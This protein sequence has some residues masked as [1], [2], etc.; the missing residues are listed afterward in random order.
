MKENEMSYKERIKR[1][2]IIFLFP[3][4]SY[5]ILGPLEI[6]CG[7]EKDFS[8]E[9]TDFIWIFLGISFAAWFLSTMICALFNEKINEKICAI[10]LGF[11]VASYIQ[12]MFMNVKLSEID[13]SAMNWEPLKTFSYINL[14]I[15]IIIILFSVILSLIMKKKWSVCAVGISAFFSVIQLVAVAFLV[16]NTAMQPDDTSDLRVSGEGQFEV[17]AGNNI[18][19]FVLDTFGNTQLENALKLYPD[20]LAE[21]SDFT[22]YNNADCHYYCTF[23]SMTH[24]LTGNEFDFNSESIQWLNDSWKSDRANKFYNILED[25]NYTCNLYS[26]SAITYTYGDIGNLN[27][28]FNN[29]QPI[30]V[31]INQGKMLSLMGKM[32]IYKYFP[33]VMKPYFEILTYQFNDVVTLKEVEDVISGNA[34]FYE[35]LNEKKLTINSDYRNA[36]IIQHLFGTHIPYTSDENAKLVEEATVDETVHGLIVICREYL[37]Q[38]K[39]LGVYDKATIIITADHGS[40]YGNDPQPIL[41][42]KREGEI[43]D[44]MQVNTAPVS[45]DDFQ[46]TVLSILGENY[47]EFG[48]S[49]FDWEEGEERNRTVY[50]REND[51][52]YPEVS[53]SSFNVYYE[54]S[55]SKDKEELVEKIK[56]GPDNVIMATPW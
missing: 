9:L 35:M 20:M 8:F 53:G 55:Y 48:A 2:G 27:R 5:G 52:K 28:K 43:H 39:K 42:V 19:V 22:F 44:Q 24:M 30:D 16:I 31:V 18:I 47:S 32:S 45:L 37:S 38:L 14:G 21:L 12:N 41:F 56:A 4:I 34:Q 26:A 49:I 29:I 23:P 51:E 11:S 46:A 1:T 40:W 10:V 7:N 25:N 13:G 17:A 36:L 50:M 54:Y 15:W 33:Y 6:Y 3:I